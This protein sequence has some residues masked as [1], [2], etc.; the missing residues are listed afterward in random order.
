MMYT[1][2]TAGGWDS[3]NNILSGIGQGADYM[4]GAFFPAPQRESIVSETTQRAAS[5]GQ[6]SRDTPAE[7]TSMISTDWWRSMGW[8]GSPYED[9]NAVSVKQAESQGLNKSVSTQ[10]D[11]I[12][13]T[14]EWVLGTTQKITTLYDQIK[15]MFSKTDVVDAKPKAGYPSGAVEQNTQI[16]VNRS[17]ETASGGA[18]FYEQVKGLF[19]LAFPQTETQTVSTS[20][21]PQTPGTAAGIGIGT[22]AIGAVILFLLLGKK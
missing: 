9:T 20:G 18:G 19:N 13:T 8:V 5:D 6:T 16:S 4:S 17:A 7:N 12:G 22:L 15:G 3:I 2:Q 21:M 10:E 14:V 1:A 11:N